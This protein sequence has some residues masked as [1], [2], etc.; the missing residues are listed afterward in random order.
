MKRLMDSS[1]T[2]KKMRQQTCGQPQKEGEKQKNI[3]RVQE[4]EV[5]GVQMDDQRIQLRVYGRWLCGWRIPQRV[6][7]SCLIE[8][9]FGQTSQRSSFGNT[10]FMQVLEPAKTPLN[11]SA[12]KAGASSPSP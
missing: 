12:G 5:N 7:G 2:T 8:T 3:S 9:H 4:G 1:E 11:A 6:Y 10:K